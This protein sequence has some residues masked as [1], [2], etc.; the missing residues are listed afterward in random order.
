MDRGLY[1]KKLR[2]E[3]GLTQK[4][5]A[6]LIGVHLSSIGKYEQ[7]AVNIPSDKLEKLAEV[8]G[9]TPG[10]LMSAGSKPLDVFK[11]LKMA[12]SRVKN[13]TGISE[14]RMLPDRL[15]SLL[16]SAALEALENY[17]DNLPNK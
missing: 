1:L 15:K 10:D 12:V 2:V 7:N 14:Y 11:T 9:V 8:Y 13:D 17:Y 4:E 3:K 6:A 5:V 16:A